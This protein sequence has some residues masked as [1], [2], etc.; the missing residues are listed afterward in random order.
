MHRCSHCNFW[1]ELSEG[2]S[3][4]S[5]A[6][7]ECRRLPP[8]PG[9]RGASADGKVISC[10]AEFP[11]TRTDTWCGEFSS[12]AAGL[13]FLVPDSSVGKAAKSI[14]PG[15]PPLLFSTREAAKRLQICERTL[16]SLAKQGAVASIRVGRRVLFSTT[17]LE[18]F[19]AKNS[20][21]S[22]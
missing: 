20:K 15:A 8:K 7:G 10:Q 6:I 19:I 9:H 21:T 11:V 3:D 18:E 16:H 1:F 14:V 5:N 12:R 13:G 2:W 22:G 17:A 4:R